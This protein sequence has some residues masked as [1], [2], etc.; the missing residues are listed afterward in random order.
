MKGGSRFSDESVWIVPGRRTSRRQEF[1]GVE[2]PILWEDTLG[3]LQPGDRLLNGRFVIKRLIGRGGMGVVYE[4]RDEVRQI[5]VALKFLSPALLQ[6]PRAVKQFLQEARISATLNHPGVLRIY[7]VH[8][9]EESYFLEMELLDG[10]TLR[11]VMLESQASRSPLPFDFVSRVAKAVCQALAHTHEFTI[12]RDIKPE[13]IGI[14]QSGEIKIM[15]FGVARLLEH[16]DG[17]RFRRSMTQWQAGTPY[18]MAPEQLTGGRDIDPRA[19][20]FSLAVI[21]YEML[22]GELPLGMARPLEE[23]RPDL[24]ERFC[25]A[26]DRA[27]SNKPLARF[28]SISAFQSELVAGLAERNALRVW[29]R[30]HPRFI[31]LAQAGALAVLTTALAWKL[32]QHWRD[33]LQVQQREMRAAWTRLGAAE[34]RVARLNQWIKEREATLQFLDRQLAIENRL[35]NAGE[36]TPEHFS[37]LI[38]L[39]NEVANAR[40]T[41]QWLEVQVSPQRSLP[42]L[43]EMLVLCQSTL[44][45]EDRSDFDTLL[46]RLLIELQIAEETLPLTEQLFQQRDLADRHWRSLV[47]RKGASSAGD[48][49]DPVPRDALQ[50]LRQQA[51]ESLARKD[52]AQALARMQ[53]FNARATAILIQSYESRLAQFQ[54]AKNS[55]TALFPVIG[56]PDLSFLADPEGL[57]ERATRARQAD[58]YDLA[59]ASLDEAASIY[60]RWTGDVEALHRR[61]DPVWDALPGDK[62]TTPMGMRF[63][64]RSGIYWSIWETRVMDFARFVQE[65]GRGHRSAG[66]F[67]KNPGYHQSPVDPVVGID[68]GTAHEFT[69]WLTSRLNKLGRFDAELPWSGS[70][71]ELAKEAGMKQPVLRGIYPKFDE[72]NSDHYRNK[73][74]EEGFDPRSFVK[75]V[76]SGQPNQFGIY[77]MEGNVWEWSQDYF[78]FA[79]LPSPTP[80]TWMLLGGGRFGEI[81]YHTF[82]P[83]EPH[84]RVIGQKEAIGFR[85]MIVIMD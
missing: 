56:P 29:M 4:A 46:S 32:A 74:R 1:K 47:Q 71:M 68:R 33:H 45:N 52:S 66:E 40:A 76:A 10:R 19:D 2:S 64:G 84:F 77:D 51:L 22:I 73:Y 53:E 42:V 54:E 11:Q 61:V 62:F 81:S 36:R 15:D 30:Q 28:E 69:T 63:V 59:I 26:V 12:H 27:L 3:L 39:S 50:W 20:Q 58:Q 80:N 23:S 57:F 83:P 78:Q 38:T 18:Y 85:V 5:D 79:G 8:R 14:T 49:V 24:P 37:K 16:Q 34:E 72:W 48:G 35:W 43:D 82:E 9:H 70:W 21:L 44:Q 55:W 65:E 75:P 31:R 67:W 13:N 41:W 7:E 6:D 17:E 25:R 60:Q